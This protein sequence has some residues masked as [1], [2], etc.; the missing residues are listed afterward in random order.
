MKQIRVSSKNTWA[1]E[2]FIT[3]KSSVT[4]GWI[5]DLVKEM[6]QTKESKGSPSI[7]ATIGM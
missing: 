4:D 5:D 2:E 6:L 3:T 7:L 1:S